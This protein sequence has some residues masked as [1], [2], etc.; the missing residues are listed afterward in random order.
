M[1]YRIRMIAIVALAIATAF[2]MTSCG[3][4]EL[5]CEAND[6]KNVVITA[7]NADTDQS[8]STSGFEVS[9][10]ESIVLEP[11]L[12]QGTM[13]IA[14][15]LAEGEESA[16]ELP[17]T[18]VPPTYQFTAIGVEPQSFKAEVSGTFHV[19]VTVSET[20]TGSVVLRTESENGPEQWKEADSLEAAAKA[21]G[22]ESFT[23]EAD[24][25]S[26]GEVTNSDF[27]YME[28]VAE[29]HYGVAA[30]DLY[31]HKG[32]ASIDEG[33][34]SFDSETYQHEWTEN[35]KGLEV[36]CFGNR[37]GEATKTIWTSGDYA[38][39]ICAYGAGGDDDFGL[40]A[41]DLSSLINSIQPE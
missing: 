31:V 12:E 22:V 4:S 9:E 10:G 2:A 35:I 17:D 40:R 19:Q 28:G 25:T 36:T 26:L 16:E 20:A 15:I 32:L 23:V 13:E 18:D 38:F 14:L 39:S 8:V 6:A 37:E 1:R 33:D 41:D 21:A 3:K 5:K 30:V 11:A 34:I 29:G 7:E 24:G 27:H